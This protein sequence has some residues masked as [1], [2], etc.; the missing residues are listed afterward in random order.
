[1]KHIL[2]SIC[3][4]YKYSLPRNETYK[5]I[6]IDPSLR[7]DSFIDNFHGGSGLIAKPP[8]KEWRGYFAITNFHVK[9]IRKPC[10]KLNVGLSNLCMQKWTLVLW[11]PPVSVMMVAIWLAHLIWHNANTEPLREI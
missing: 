2:P 11:L 8:L 1:M 10:T 4:F 9:Q 3:T 6:C 5:S 7:D